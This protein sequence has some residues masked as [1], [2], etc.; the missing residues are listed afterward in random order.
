MWLI[1][2]WLFRVDNSRGLR[3]WE[4]CVCQNDEGHSGQSGAGQKT[5]KAFK[6]LA[7]P[8]V[9][10]YPSQ[11]PV[12]LFIWPH[13]SSMHINALTYIEIN[14]ESQN[15]NLQ[16]Y[17]LKNYN[18]HSSSVTRP[19]RY[20]GLEHCCCFISD[21]LQKLHWYQTVI[22]HRQAMQAHVSLQTD[23]PSS[24]FQI[25]EEACPKG[26]KHIF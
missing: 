5:H 25:S 14:P 13:F 18:K 26:V 23:Q 7:R 4:A 6:Q 11:M 8:C 1:R 2:I 16:G 10:N 19:S 15:G 22:L 9:K 21:F 24:L 3:K 20:I 17:H 12:T